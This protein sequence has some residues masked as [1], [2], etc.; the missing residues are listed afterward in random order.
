MQKT[1][2][3]TRTIKKNKEMHNE[4]KTRL[5]CSSKKFLVFM[6]H[7]CFISGFLP[8]RAGNLDSRENIF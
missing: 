6:H 4:K 5:E 3:I 2:E 8:N 7:D 1:E